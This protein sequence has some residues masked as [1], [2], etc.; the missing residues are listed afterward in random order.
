MA[1]EIRDRN[2]GAARRALLRIGRLASDLPNEFEDGDEI[3]RSAGA[4]LEELCGLDP[5]H[6]RDA[7]VLRREFADE[8]AAPAQ[9][10]QSARRSPSA[11]EEAKS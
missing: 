4:A 7:R 1:D 8:F 11:G 9:G 6:P 2:L 10:E 5:S 3:A